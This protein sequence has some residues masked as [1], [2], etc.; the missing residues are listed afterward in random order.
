MAGG[1]GTRLWPLS[2]QGTP[3]Q[4]LPLVGGRSLLQ[5][6]VERSRASVP[7]ERI[8]I[9][10]GA[11]QAAQV[12]EQLPELPAENILGEPVGRDSLNAVAWPAA[13]LARRD[14]EAVIAQVTADHLIEPIAGFAATLQ[15][16]F[17]LA[18]ARADVLVTLGVVPTSP[19]TGYGYLHRGAALPGFSGAH[20]VLGF[21]EKPGL[22]VAAEYLASGEYWWNAGMFVWRA[23]TILDQ[24]LALLPLTH[25]AV[26]ELAEFPERLPEIFPTLVKISIDY[27]IIEPVAAGL[28]SATV[29]AVGLEVSWRDVGGWASLASV[30]ETDPDGNA[31]QGR[32]VTVDATGNVLVNADPE[33]VVGVIG[34]RETVVVRTPSAT[35]VVA[36]DQAERVKELVAAITD[37]AGREFA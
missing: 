37:E 10:T 18:E 25:A 22:E 20:Q 1:S 4:L 8:L 16:A 5:L 36:L 24:V 33:A 3:K 29:V 31:R 15:T 11:A 34:L 2:R 7:A 9:V 13:V 19:H 32:V 17:E 27:A 14:P 6:A 35:L 28:G 30:L 21:T 26:T 23:Q 12:A